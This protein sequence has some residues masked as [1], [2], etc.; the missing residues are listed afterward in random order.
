[1]FAL[2]GRNSERLF[3]RF[4]RDPMGAVILREGRSLGAVLAEHERLR[5]FPPGSLGRAYVEFMNREQIS[6]EG[7]AEATESVREREELDADQLLF[8]DR[9]R[10]MH[11]LWHVVTGYSRDIVG[12]VALMAFSYRQLRTPAFALIAGFA[13][14]FLELRVPGA[15]ALLSGAWRRAGSAPWLPVQDWETLL[16]RPLDEVR[17]ELGVGPPPAYTRHFRVGRALVPEA[18]A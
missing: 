1:V 8:E 5:A 7:L 2:N 11:D 13:Y 9:I 4:A 3:R 18:A 6:A 12:E 10:D 14:L 16:A 17:A 15:R